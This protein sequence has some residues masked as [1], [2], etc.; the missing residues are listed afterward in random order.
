M[1]KP[2]FEDSFSKSFAELDEIIRPPLFSMLNGPSFGY[3]PTLA[4]SEQL[5]QDIVERLC[6]LSLERTP[7]WIVTG[8]LAYILISKGHLA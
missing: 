4:F 1:S 6:F 3:F 8:L 7:T 5:S 2:C